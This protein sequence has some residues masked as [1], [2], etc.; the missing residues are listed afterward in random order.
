[1][2]IQQLQFDLNAA[3]NERDAALQASLCRKLLADCISF[4]YQKLQ[5]QV[6]EQATMLELI[7]GEAVFAYIHNRDIIKSLHYVRI[8]GMNADH[9]RH[10][11]KAE[12][13]T[14][15]GHMTY[16]IGLLAAREAGTDSTYQDPPYMSEEKTRQLYIDLYLRESGWDVPKE[17]EPD[18]SA[19]MREGG[20]A[21]NS[22]RNQIRPGKAGIEIEVHGMPNATGIGYCDYVLYGRDGKPL[23]IVEVKKTSVDANRGRK[24]VVDYGKCMKARYGYTPILY[25]TNA[26]ETK[27]I[28]GIYPDRAISTFHSLDD[29][30]WMIRNRK[31][32]P[33]TDLNI[34]TEI[35]ER[36]YQHRAITKICE[37]L[38]QNF[39]KAL[40][41]MATGTGKTRVSIS[42]V[43]VLARNH[44]IKT[45]LFLAD[46]TALVNQ[47]KRAFA[48]YLPEF[49]ICELSGTGPRDYNARLM[50]CTYQTMIN[51]IDA[52]KKQFSPGRFD[53]IIID[54][55][56]RSI[57]NRYASIFSYFDSF[58]IGLTATPKEEV[59]ANTYSIFGCEPGQPT[60]DY[61]LEEAIS[62]HY[63]VGYKVKNRTSRLLTE[64]VRYGNL[65]EE[66]KHQLE[67]YLKG[68]VPSPDF[69][70]SG[71]EI[72]RYL[73]NKTTCSLVLDELMQE[74]LRTDGGETL[75]KTV[76]FA[77][78]HKHAQMIVDQFNDHYPQYPPEYC[79]LIDNTVKGGDDLILQFEN[80]PGFR[81]AVSVD[82][83]DT[84]VDV[85]EIL[86]LVFFKTVRSKIK[87]VQMIGRGTR[88]C[89]NI[90]GPGKNKSGF[91]IFDY[92]GNF[93][94][95]DKNTEGSEGKEPLT[96]SQRL[97]Q[98]RLDM[99]SELQKIE[100]QE[101]TWFKAYYEQTKKELHSTVVGMK[102]NQNRRQ[103]RDALQYVDEFYDLKTWVS[104]SPVMIIR[105]K[106]YLTP[107]V[108]SGLNGSYQKVAFDIRMYYA[109]CA[110]LAKQGLNKVSRHV[111]RLRQIAKY[112]LE[113]KASVPQVLAKANDLREAAGNEFWENPQI[114]ELERL[115]GSLR[116]LM[117]YLDDSGKSKVD[118]TIDDIITESAYQ[119]EDTVIDIRTYREK[120]IDYLAEHTDHEVIKKIRNLEPITRDDL[121]ELELILW[122][123]LGTQEEY[124]ATTEIGN[125]AAFIRSLT[126][127]EQ[128]VVN[129][130]FGEYLRGNVLNSQ[131]QE[132]V[133]T[134]IDYVREN[135]DIEVGD[136]VN[137]EPFDHYD[138][139][140]LFGEKVPIVVEIVNTLHSSVQAA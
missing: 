109:E 66:Q 18:G 46:R 39:R 126:G 137:E 81:I 47:A 60:D 2:N 94:Y 84:G 98:I 48:K 86:N 53:L 140:E 26:Y 93:E 123:E 14:A 57:F 61:S 100:Y 70:I 124:Q 12:A 9:D 4:I 32:K 41:V 135:G 13:K 16:L 120:V 49:T 92:C 119:P 85:P 64:G 52:E 122:H 79:Q 50:F 31:R 62:A 59:E 138:L 65:T 90:Y 89:E 73:Y 11:R 134:I 67:E 10:V 21:Y 19:V 111:K 103:V 25:Y 113:E 6:P 91:L 63:L 15:L 96:L 69:D 106:K 87:F 17:D 45:V 107:L 56:H 28:D 80:D 116:E 74:G 3:A 117:D 58:L 99:L 35:T 38:N 115:R 33:I 1:M 118:V 36:P 112:L 114:P 8:L 77:Y 97:F 82:M 51:Y 131:Q 5:M 55:A 125:L 76:I 127:V 83:L 88:L 40:L 27:I 42:I 29:L 78:N 37:R 102:R 24:Q 23:A 43:D 30:E 132:F 68:I 71:S 121:I 54:E 101:D 105:A 7:D 128:E 130:K 72:F 95:F 133:Q 20:T 34:N 104:L 129:Q 139:T 136:L 75:G 110:V 22:V 44:W 108:D